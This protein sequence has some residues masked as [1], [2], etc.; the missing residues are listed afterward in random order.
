MLN[1]Q[2]FID[3]LY[4]HPRANYNHKKRFGGYLNYKRILN[5]Q[6][7][8]I[9]KSEHLTPVKS[10]TDG[11]PIYFLTGKKYLYQ[12]LFCIQSLVKVTDKKFRF[13]LIDDGTFDEEITT[14]IA[15]LLP[16]ADIITAAIINKNL[17]KVLPENEF[18]I[19]H[20]KRKEYPHIKKLTD[21]HTIPGTWKLVLDSDMLFW[22][23]PKQIID[24]LN[25]PSAP[26]HMTDCERSYGYSENLMEKLKGHKI[27]DLINVGVLG[28]NSEAINWKDLEHWI[29]V[30]EKQEGKT[31]YLEQALS[32][33]LIA[34]LH[35]EALDTGNYKVNPTK[36]DVLNNVGVLHHYVDLSKEW[37]FTQAWKNI[38]FKPSKSE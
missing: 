36:E 34:D 29:S 6:K 3:V 33:M 2:Y 21:I 22:N 9:S 4:R 23:E 14:K 1:F 31:Y 18:P 7:E 10:Q 19:L 13:V 26:L 11:S 32:A 30:L 35:A 5:S 24:W 8:M 38:I 16:H 37:Y 25:N 17:Y 28:L 20:Q 27:P 12:T 15:Q